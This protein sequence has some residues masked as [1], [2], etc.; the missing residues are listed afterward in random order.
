M[1]KLIQKN[2]K[3]DAIITDPPY[4]ITANKFDIIIPFEQMW[5]KINK[6][7]KNNIP[8]I[9]F[10]NEPFSS[11]L[12]LSNLKEYKYDW[13][14][15]KILKTGHLNAKIKPMLQHEIISVFGKGKI[16]YYPIMEEG[17]PQHGEGNRKRIHSINYSKQNNNYKD[18]KGNTFKYPSTLSIKIQKVHPS[19]C[20]HPNQKPVL[21]LEYLI[22]TYTNKDDLILDFTAGSFTTAVACINTNRKFIGIEL[23]KKHY[24]NGI[25][26]I[27]EVLNGKND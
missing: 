16:N 12:R 1:D 27:K 13:I 6:L 11:A 2:I 23:D 5:F 22:K 20:I 19:K 17:K 24:N 7:R 15:N 25:N 14:W 3:F 9:L 8:I 10:G 4:G 18:K 26:R 21:L